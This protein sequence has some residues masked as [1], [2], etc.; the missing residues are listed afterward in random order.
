MRERDTERGMD[1]KALVG[2]VTPR[3]QASLFILHTWQKAPRLSGTHIYF[4]NKSSMGST[5]T[6]GHMETA[7]TNIVEFMGQ[8]ESKVYNFC[9]IFKFSRYH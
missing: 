5:K 2:L 7:S 9:Q 6:E 4:P 3:R 1:F 8:P